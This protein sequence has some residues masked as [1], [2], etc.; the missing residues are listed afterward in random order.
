MEQADSRSMWLFD[1]D[2]HPDPSRQ[3]VFGEVPAD[4]LVRAGLVG[5]DAA[6]LG[7]KRTQRPGHA[8]MGT[9]RGRTP[10]PAPRRS[11][12]FTLQS[13]KSTGML[14]IWLIIPRSLQRISLSSTRD[15][16]GRN[17]SAAEIMRRRVARARLAPMQ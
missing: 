10:G 17:S 16:P 14:F 12:A 8:L 13:A 11:R 4:D 1:F 7:E 2:L 3:P 5:P 6:T 9:V 15:R